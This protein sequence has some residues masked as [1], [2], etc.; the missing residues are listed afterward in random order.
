MEKTRLDV[1]LVNNKN[2]ESRNIA[3]KLI[4]DGKV[5]VNDIIVTKNN[6]GVSELD[7]VEI[8]ENEKYVSRGAY[9]LLKGIEEFK[10]ELKDKVALDI[11][12]STGGFTQVLLESGV[13]KVYCIDVGTD[14]LHSKIKNDKKVVVYEKT[15]F[16]DVIPSYFYEPIEFICCDVSFIS[17]KQIIRKIFE[18]DFHNIEAIFLLKPQFEIGK[19]EIDKTHGVVK[20]PR[21]HKKVIDDIKEFCKNNNVEFMGICNSPITGAKLNNNEFLIHLF[22][23]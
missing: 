2:V 23:R 18:L 22:L 10:P 14:Q 13:R 16:K 3:S 20:D 7:K 12:S 6:Y 15:N 5:V 1:Y 19:E 17:I 9:K 21:L 11:G 4:E 8:I